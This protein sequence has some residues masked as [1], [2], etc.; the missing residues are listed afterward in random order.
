MLGKV[1]EVIG[2][3][4]WPHHPTAKDTLEM[5][6]R[7]GETPEWLRAAI[8]V[9]ATDI[10]CQT[11]TYALRG[12]THE[13]RAV[14]EL[15]RASLEGPA[16]QQFETYEQRYQ[17]LGTILSN[18]EGDD[19][20]AARNALGLHVN[21]LTVLRDLA[22]LPSEQR[23]L[24]ARTVAIH[25]EVLEAS[26]DSQARRATSTV[27]LQQVQATRM[28]ELVTQPGFPPGE[29]AQLRALA[30]R[31]SAAAPSRDRLAAVDVMQIALEA[32]GT[33]FEDNTTQT[34]EALAIL[35]SASP[36]QVAEMA[37]RGAAP[38]GDVDGVPG[39][40]VVFDS[41]VADR[42]PAS[43]KSAIML[44][45]E[46]AALPRGIEVLSALT[47]GSGDL[48]SYQC[49]AARVLFKAD[50]ALA[51]LP[52][53][54]PDEAHLTAARE[55]ANQVVQAADG[56]FDA[57]DTAQRKIAFNAV[58]NGL[59]RTGPGSEYQK[60]DEYLRSLTGEMLESNSLVTDGVM[61]ALNRSGIAGRF[62][63]TAPT[64]LNRSAIAAAAQTAVAVG[65]V[66]VPA[67]ALQ[68]LRDAAGALRD[69]GEAS[70]PERALAALVQAVITASA[71]NDLLTLTH[72][73]IA[74]A[75]RFGLRESAA[76][77]QVLWD[78]F[79]AG[80][81]SP[82]DAVR[83][84]ADLAASAE[85]DAAMKKTIAQVKAKASFAEGSAWV[86]QASVTTP[87]DVGNFLRTIAWNL[88]L[89]DRAKVTGGQV[90]GVDVGPF[91]I[92]SSSQGGFSAAVRFPFRLS[93]QSDQV[94]EL[95][96]STQ[97]FYFSVGTQS[98]RVARA[99]FGVGFSRGLVS[100]GNYGVSARI[101]DAEMKAG[102][103]RQ[104]QVGVLVRVPRDKTTEQRNRTEFATMMVDIVKPNEARLPVGLQEASPLEAVLACHP[105][106]SVNLLGQY[107]RKAVKGETSFGMFLSGK[108]GPFQPR[109]GGAI[110]RRG[111]ITKTRADERTGYFQFNE[112]KQNVLDSTVT[113]TLATASWKVWQNENGSKG[114]TWGGLT[115][116]SRLA[117]RSIRGTETTLRLTT[118]DG[119]TLPLQSRLISDF[120]QVDDFVKTIRAE[121]P[122]W[123][124]H[125]V[126][127][128]KYPEVD[129][130]QPWTDE[131]EQ[132]SSE[133]DLKRLIDEVRA[134]DSE[135][136]QY[137]L[138]RALQE[139]TAPRIDALNARIAL[140][141][142][143]GNAGQKTELEGMRDALLADPSSWQSRRL[144]VNERANVTRQPGNAAVV[145][146]QVSSVADASHNWLLYP[147][148]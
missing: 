8:D 39:L 105:Y 30:N 130:A 34:F 46:I 17:K 19:A 127:Y 134:K 61:G 133:L 74:I 113:T 37:A 140:A 11:A 57:I 71:S 41:E 35:S 114:L 2:W 106:A 27:R 144:V 16:F 66:G 86:G 70:P 33:A 59:M 75:P 54:H 84:L 78:E 58:R 60:I 141:E 103:E 116:V 120:S 51:Q 81:K 94:V 99:G 44:A 21:P 32:A 124:N 48:S 131:L 95:G 111:Q 18:A 142:R 76:D 97:A 77:V 98:T 128:T 132:A 85:P 80:Q 65:I 125:G 119:E 146:G 102:Y 104:S 93:E 143:R 23:D 50:H 136:M 52:A 135:F 96:M 145:L 123:I 13:A 12:I 82:V 63:I 107:D 83:A 87:D 100:H 90:T 89:R 7:A 108:V 49:V 139:A 137:L 25:F 117:E 47:V 69:G 79:Q 68:E 24:V 4:P 31:L 109:V 6:P 45:R 29:R 14:W 22:A 148:N 53:S 28:D 112:R 56:S 129:P 15:L 118:E 72:D 3:N 40:P 38:T 88:K 67:E 26:V 126:N 20:Q 121:L 122:G 101:V 36:A 73:Q 138:V 5:A 147:R 115:G 9:Q 1:V 62:P 55:G 42:D 91:P 43:F 10:V 92:V 64:A 110:G